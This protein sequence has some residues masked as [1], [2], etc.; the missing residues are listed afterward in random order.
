VS[1]LSSDPNCK[2]CRGAG[3]CACLSP[4]PAGKTCSDCA[5]VVRCATMFGQD[6]NDTACQFFPSRWREAVSP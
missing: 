4:L 2:H 5:H 6:A 1:A 3:C